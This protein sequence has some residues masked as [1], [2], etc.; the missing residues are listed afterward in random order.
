MNHSVG[1]YV[2]GQAR[3]NGIE[4]FWAMLKRGYVG[5]IHCFSAK[6]LQ[7]YLNEFAARHGLRDRDTIQMMDTFVFR[8]IGRRLTFAQLAD[9]GAT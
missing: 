6:H 5:T 2:R 3:I 9:E 7:C 8:M 4:E 1:E